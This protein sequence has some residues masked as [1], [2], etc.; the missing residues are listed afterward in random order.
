ML[1]RMHPIP[2]AAL[3]APALAALLALSGCKRADAPT[4][5]VAG[6]SAS[7]PASTGTPPSAVPQSPDAQVG[8][9]KSP[10]GPTSADRTPP[11]GATGM[12]GGAPASS[13]ASAA[14]RP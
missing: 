1:N 7:A 4:P 10:G 8:A 14:S 9:G 3:L 5:G 13:P 6:G 2:A 11:P 12:G